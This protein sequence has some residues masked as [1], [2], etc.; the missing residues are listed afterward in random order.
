MARASA[1]VGG[2]A[3]VA[4]E[5]AALRAQ[6]AQAEAQRDQLRELLD[7]LCRAL[8]EDAVA[9][10]GGATG[11]EGLAV[12]G[13]LAGLAR[14]MGAMSGEVAATHEGAEYLSDSLQDLKRRS[15][16]QIDQVQAVTFSLATVAEL[17]DK[18]GTL[19]GESAELAERTDSVSREIASDMQ[20][21][22]Q[23]MHRIEAAS[24]RITGVVGDIESIAMQ[25]NI[26][27]LNA[28]IQA[29]RAGEAGL[30]FSVVA[31]EVR[32]LANTT[33][34]LA[35]TIGGM[36]KDSLDAAKDGADVVEETQKQVGAI[37]GMSHDTLVALGALRDLANDQATRVADLLDS[38]EGTVGAATENAR[39]VSTLSELAAANASRPAPG[40]L[41]VAGPP[42]RVD[43][44]PAGAAMAGT[45]IELF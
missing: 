23:A 1:P 18:S 30:G 17:A 11:A 7:R 8:D 41:A 32:R 16:A 35:M 12:N 43:A 37:C 38:V 28:G 33:K 27:A 9:P 6:L 5:V 22:T 2:G 19:A 10:L 42:G 25:T 45:A 13:A 3:A 29:A 20:N 4:P 26:L 31:E 36:A 14:R 39:L 15:N 34:G 40:A 44:Q 24:G 21:L